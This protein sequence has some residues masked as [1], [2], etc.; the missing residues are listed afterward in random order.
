MRMRST[1]SAVA[2]SHLTILSFSLPL[3]RLSLSPPQLTCAAI[4]KTTIGVGVDDE[5]RKRTWMADA[6]ECIKRKSFET[7]RR[8]R[9][10]H[11]NRGWTRRATDSHE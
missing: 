9:A 3:T 1:R 2:S 5:D 11:G 10:A 8:R 4:V 6:D 7:V